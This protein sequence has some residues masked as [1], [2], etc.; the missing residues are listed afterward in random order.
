MKSLVNLNDLMERRLLSKSKP[1]K[2]R[3]RKVEDKSQP[4]PN[5]D[6]SQMARVGHASLSDIKQHSQLD[7]QYGG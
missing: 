2:K 4:L 5:T 6:S 1:W 3:G 7:S